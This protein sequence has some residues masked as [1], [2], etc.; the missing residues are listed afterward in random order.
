MVLNLRIL[1]KIKSLYLLFYGHL[2]GGVKL[3]RRLG[4]TVGN[5]CRIYTRVWGSEPF[6]ISIG[7][8]VTITDG[9][10]ILTHDGATWLIRNEHGCRFQ[11]FAAVEIGDNVFIGVNAIIMPGIT[12]GSNVIIGAGSVVTKNLSSNGVYV[13]NPAKFIKKFIDY[14][15]K[16]IG[17]CVNDSELVHF[18]SNYE[19]LV[20]QSI[21][22]HN[23]KKK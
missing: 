16:V 23:D 8:R 15:Q 17:S 11:R 21:E 2:F 3:A 4:V 20:Y 19:N 18:K 1:K 10:K 9:V 12:I 7:N 5:D 14:E 13:G 22:L 6:L